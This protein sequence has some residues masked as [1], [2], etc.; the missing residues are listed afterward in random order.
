MPEAIKD[1]PVLDIKDIESAYYLRLQVLDKP[2]VMARISTILSQ[3][4]IS[5]E[6]LIQKDVKKGQVPIVIITDRVIEQSMND[7]IQELENLDQVDGSSKDQ[8]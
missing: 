5:I 7:A 2:G 4:D 8:G 3:Y 1:I 6:S